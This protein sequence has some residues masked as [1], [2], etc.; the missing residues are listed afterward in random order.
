GP[1]ADPAGIQGK[2]AAEA[3]ALIEEAGATFVSRG[4]DSGTHQMELSFWEEVGVGT[5]GGDWYL[6]TGQGMGETLTI[7]AERQAYT[8][9]DRATWLENSD[10]EQLALLVEGD[11][12]LFNVYHVMIVNPERHDINLDGARAFVEFLVAPETQQM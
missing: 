2:T 5:P 7:A 4:D 9:T 8:L 3:F 12:A 6:E 10:P 11:A 1:P